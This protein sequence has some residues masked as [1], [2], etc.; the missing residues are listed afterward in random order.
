MCWLCGACVEAESVQSFVYGQLRP[1]ITKQVP[2]QATAGDKLYRPHTRP[3][4]RDTHPPNV[5]FSVA[6]HTE[7]QKKGTQG[8]WAPD[9]KSTRLNSSHSGESRMPS[10]A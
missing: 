10:S 6:T 3:Y 9:R 8:A 1:Y 2:T 5:H 7:A 4:A